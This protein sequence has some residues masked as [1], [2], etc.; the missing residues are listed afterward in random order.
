M[1]R[2]C[3]GDSRIFVICHLLFFRNT[4]KAI[5]QFWEL[6]IGKKV[7]SWPSRTKT[8][9]STYEKCWNPLEVRQSWS[10]MSQFA[11][12]CVFYDGSVRA[13][14][15]KSV[16]SCIAASLWNSRLCIKEQCTPNTTVSYH[17][18]IVLVTLFP[19]GRTSY[20]TQE[21]HEIRWSTPV[22]DHASNQLQMHRGFRYFDALSLFL[23]FYDLYMSPPWTCAYGF[24]FHQIIPTT[25][26][27]HVVNGGLNRS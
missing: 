3:V 19:I 26:D 15:A 16:K 18:G 10:E 9:S 27:V 13:R 20:I 25:R 4:W 12:S 23:P 14:T 6:N 8:A 17:V 11:T 22:P 2:K 21:Q 1:L 24:L 7:T 5:V